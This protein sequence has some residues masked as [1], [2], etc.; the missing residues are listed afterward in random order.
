MPTRR[1]LPPALLVP[2]H[3]V[4]VICHWTAGG[5]RVSANDRVHYHAILED[6]EALGPGGDVRVVPGIHSIADN[7]SARDGDYAAHTAKCNTGSI[8]LAVA[9]MFEAT[10][11]HPGRYLLTQ[12]LWERLAQAA[13]ECCRRYGI[14]VTPE[15]VLQHGEVERQLGI[16]QSGK[17]DI[18]FLPWDP[19]LEPHEVCD[20][21]RRKV[22]WYLEQVK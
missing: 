4:R 7:D 15:T 1:V 14:A 8:G 12:L 17:W 2:A 19:D 5:Y 22:S 20:Q 6:L 9:C 11:Q 21:F 18:T 10:C 13:A 16:P 3:P